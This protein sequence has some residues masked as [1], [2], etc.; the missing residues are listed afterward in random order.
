L[1]S[2]DHFV[3]ERLK[4]EGY[5]R[6]VD[7]MIFFS[8]TN[9]L[10]NMKTIIEF[11]DSVRVEIHEKKIKSGLTQ[12]GFTFLGHQIFS[13]HFTFTNQA[14]RRSRKNVDKA[15]I[16]FKFKKIDFKNYRSRI[17]GTLGFMDM[18]NCKSIKKDILKKTLLI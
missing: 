16:L 4:I 17:F 18:G 14:I 9:L 1:N 11:L 5:I 6:Y 13:T 15:N 12:D 3:K 10:Q 8:K 2:F 7:D